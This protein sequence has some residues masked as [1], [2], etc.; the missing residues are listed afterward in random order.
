MPESFRVLSG[1]LLDNALCLFVLLFPDHTQPSTAPLFAR[2]IRGYNP[3]Q[4]CILPNPPQ[5]DYCNPTV[6]V[7]APSRFPAGRERI[8]R[9]NA[10]RCPS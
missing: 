7:K 4:V 8:Y 6:L 1:A 3:A 9:T 5:L 10:S 2:D